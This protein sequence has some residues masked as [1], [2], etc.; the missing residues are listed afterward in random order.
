MLAPVDF[1]T[2]SKTQRCFR[3]IAKITKEKLLYFVSMS[4]LIMGFE[5][6]G[7]KQK[8]EKE[9]LLTELVLELS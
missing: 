5:L 2:L 4:A 9:K 3:N 1:L 6:G 8:H 7:K